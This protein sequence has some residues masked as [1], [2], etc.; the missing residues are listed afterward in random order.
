MAPPRPEEATP[1]ELVRRALVGF[2]LL[3]YAFVVWAAIAAY[4][5]KWIGRGLLRRISTGFG[6]T[7]V[8]AAE[9]EKAGLIKVGQVGSLR[10]DLIPAEITDEL[11]K[12]Q[13][14]VAPHPFPEIR[15]QL[16]YEL[17]RPVDEIFAE[18]DVDA[19]AAASLG[20]VHRAVLEDGTE[21]AVKVQY[22]GIEKAVAVDM[23]VTRLGLWVFN[24]L[25]VADTRRIYDELLEAIH[26]EMDYIR[27]GETAEEVNRNLGLAEELAG[28]YVIP[29]IHWQYTTKRVLT[30][31]FLHGIKINHQAELRAAGFDIDE[32]A[33]RTAKIFLRQIFMDGLFHADPHP[34]NLFVDSEGRIVLLDFGMN[35]RLEPHI[36]DAIRRNLV[37][38]IT[39]DVDMYAETL[40]EAGFVDRSDLPKVRELA[41]IQFDPRF[42][43]LSA[44]ESARMDF[45]SYFGE[46]REK[47]RDI[48]SFQ[49]PNGVV[50]W[51][52][53]LGLL[54]ALC[55]E[56]SPDARP[57]DVVGPYV[58]EF[59]QG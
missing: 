44:R 3:V 21:V 38:T 10:S 8:R 28:T 20:Q 56:L 1:L 15:A 59:L 39:M 45:Q 53:A 55:G 4:R 17:G 2:G 25:T 11:S 13:D 9:R 33:L 30:M 35:R 58:L 43:N 27:E 6:R 48:K 42:F 34:G 29:H 41:T 12:L 14:R 40:A 7:F 50:M 31:E 37:A 5:R 24:F 54:M 49:L 52:R 26:G 47:M 16:E 23:A 51:G 57:N 36:R 22:P 18:F 46:T 32:I 19:I